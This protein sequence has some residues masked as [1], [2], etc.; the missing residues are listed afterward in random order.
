MDTSL[1]NLSDVE[2][3]IINIGG[4]NE[5]SFEIFDV[6]LSVVN[7]I[8]RVILTNIKTLVFRGFPH[9]DN[10][11]N[12]EINKSKFNNE[13]LKH[14]IS[15]VPIFQPDDSLFE[16]MINQ[17]EVRLHVINDTNNSL[18]VTTKDFELYNKSTN[19]I[20]LSAD[21]NIR[22]LFPADPISRNFI[23]IC[24]LMPKISE[25]D[26]PEEL[27][28]TIDFSVGTAKE[29]A[30]WNMV[31]K[32]CF[33][34]KKDDATIEKFIQKDKI[35]VEKFFK[36]D[37]LSIHKYMSQEMT[38]SE[39]KDFKILDAQRIFIPNHY[40]M[41]IESTGVFSNQ[42]IVIKACEY[43]DFKL[44]E[45][46]TFLKIPHIDTDTIDKNNYAMQIDQTNTDPTF[47]LYI[48]DDDYTIGKMI[49]K[50]LYIMFN[51]SIYYV[52]F[53]KE[54]PHDL[55]C[56]VSFTYKNVVTVENVFS[57]LRH[58]VN[59]LMKTIRIISSNFRK[60]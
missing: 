5:L 14:R 12:I 37:M 13:Y 38:E 47:V 4:Q 34:N 27:K 57:D 52:S 41:Y 19:K 26:E 56:I 2:P 15:C 45:L 46:D 6:E 33:E 23:P 11:I 48:K 54:H 40:I 50:Y 29:D 1:L 17:Y 59:K 21:F 43:L 58:V 39:L 10:L 35:T 32:C 8:R 60:E 22:E 16:A 31:S 42:T 49:E 28:L 20:V 55:H 24:C 44:N 9:K 30:C 18:Y 3:K 51:K 25:D 53:K 7:A 36:N